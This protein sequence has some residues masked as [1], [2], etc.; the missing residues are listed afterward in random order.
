[1]VIHGDTANQLIVS[2]RTS[3]DR[4]VISLFVVDAGAPG[5]HLR[6]YPTIDGQRA[7]EIEFRDVQLQST[8]LLG[9]P[10]DGAALLESAV[11]RGIAALCAEAV[12][13]MER[14]LELTAEHLRS[15]KQFGQPIGQFQA[16]QH[17]IADMAIALE[18]SRSVAVL[19]AARID[20]Q[21]R[22]E[23][24]RAVSAAK[25]MV[26]RCGRLVSHWAVQLHGGMGMT[27]DVPVGYYFK[28]LTA[29][30]CMWGNAEHHVELYGD[31]M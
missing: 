15:R 21:D 27:D 12:G 30:D 25:A 22:V 19:A 2:A 4:A 1:M 24:R 16:L 26:G 6:G 14:L 7:A 28:R 29:I 9:S 31:L 17:R 23:R 3:D 13:A 11:D 20:S 5:V 18:Q 10:Q 8:A